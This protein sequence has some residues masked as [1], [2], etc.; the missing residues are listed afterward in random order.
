MV[1]LHNWVQSNVPSMHS[2]ISVHLYWSEHMSVMKFALEEHELACCY[3]AIQSSMAI[4]CSYQCKYDCLC[5]L[6]SQCCKS[7]CSFQLCCCIIECNYLFQ[8]HIH[9]YLDVRM[10]HMLLIMFASNCFSS[11]HCMY[12]CLNQV[13][14]QCYKSMCSFQLC[15]CII[16]CNHLFQAHIHYCL[17]VGVIACQ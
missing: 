3:C 15:C 9:W 6:C 1:F 16:E 12:G 11:H 4:I 13:C 7:I 2:L 8:E 17:N 5:L 10:N 14:S